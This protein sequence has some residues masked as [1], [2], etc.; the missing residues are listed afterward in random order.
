MLKWV[1][2]I[3]CCA[4]LLVHSASAATLTAAQQKAL[5]AYLTQA[6]KEAKK[7]RETVELVNSQVADLNADG[8]DEVVFEVHHY[9]GTYSSSSIVLLSDRGKGYQLAARTNDALGNISAFELK[10]GLIY[11]HA[12]WPKPSDP[13][14]CPSLKKTAIYAWRGNQ[15]V[16]NPAISTAGSGHQASKT[17]DQPRHPAANGPAQRLSHQQEEWKFLTVN[18]LKLAGV[19]NAAGIKALNVFCEAKTPALAVAFQAAQPDPVYL[20]IE[21]ARVIYRFKL[22]QQP[23]HGDFRIVSLSS[24]AFPKALRSGQTVAKVKINGV[25]HGNLSLHNAGPASR[26][27]LSSCY[28]Y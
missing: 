19:G 14:C 5:N 9:G 25:S 18:G 27:A 24:S 23:R 2:G 21:I 17:T 11:V 22:V 4:G 16:L 3:I 6:N 28:R 12:L 13:R 8:K 10:N 7:V 20:E 15:L 1:C 26:S